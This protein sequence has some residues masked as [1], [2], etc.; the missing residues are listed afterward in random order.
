MSKYQV[1]RQLARMLLD[2]VSDTA[3]QRMVED[4][5]IQKQSL[6]EIAWRRAGNLLT[7]FVTYKP[8]GE[9]VDF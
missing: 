2:N 4:S 3:Y 9:V 1:Q 5:R 6:Q 7:S 8:G